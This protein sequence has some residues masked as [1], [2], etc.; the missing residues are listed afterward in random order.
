MTD[1]A[2]APRPWHALRPFREQSH[3]SHLGLVAGGVV[4]WWAGFLGGLA[5]L[6]GEPVATGAGLDAR[7]G[8]QLAGALAGV[9]VAAYFAVALFRARGGPLSNLLYPGLIAATGTLDAPLVAVYGSAPPGTF[10]TAALESSR[11]VG[12]GELLVAAVTTVATVVFVVGYGVVVASPATIARVVRR[13]P[14]MPGVY[15]FDREAVDAETVGQV[16]VSTAR[17]WAGDE[18]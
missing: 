7:R 2:P 14:A 5:V 16:G 12:V 10:T 1:D 18:E 8:R 3:L 9:A 15:D 6:G 11:L 4:L 13:L 17:G